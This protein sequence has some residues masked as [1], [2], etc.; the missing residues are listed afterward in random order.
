MKKGI[1][2]GVIGVHVALVVVMALGA[3]LSFSKKKKTPLAVRTITPKQIA[4]VP[5]PQAAPA[6]PVAPPEPKPV[7]E[8]KPAAPQKKPMPKKE[9]PKKTAAKPAPAKKPSPKKSAATKPEPPPK[10]PKKLLQ[11]LEESIAKIDG[12]RDKL[13]AQKKLEPPKSLSPPPPQELFEE[14]ES[15]SDAMREQ[16]TLVSYLHQVLN[17]PDHGEVKIELTLRRDG[18]VAR[19]VVLKSESEKNKTYL[20]KSLSHLKFPILDGMFSNKNQQTFI[21]TFCNEL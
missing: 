7:A 10:V 4:A 9:E 14:R 12:K 16:E 20:E 8:P 19:L 1:W 5:Q 17:L 11:E 21:L 18:S 15:L 2:I 3:P 13:A 6:A